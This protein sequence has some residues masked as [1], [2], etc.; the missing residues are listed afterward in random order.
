[1]A[2]EAQRHNLD[3]LAMHLDLYLLDFLKHDALGMEQEAAGLIGKPAYEDVILEYKSGTAAYAGQFA[4]ARDLTR[5][6][7]DSAQRVDE[8]ETAAG[9][10][11]EAAMREA[12]IGNFDRAKQQV[13][14]ATTLS[15]G[16]DV[17][18]ICAIVLAL[19]SDST[20]AKRLADNLSKRFPEDT[21]TQL[22]YLPMIHAAALLRGSD[23]AGAIEALVT[24]APYE[25]ANGIVF[26][27]A[28]LRGEAYLTAKQGP[29]AAAEFQKILD[30]AGI[31]NINPIGALAHLQLARAHA[32]SRDATKA[33]ADYQEFFTLWKN[34]DS[35]IPILNQAK[36]EYAKLQ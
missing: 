2:Q 31:V 11:A 33:R 29:A 16:R 3:S 7:T 27:P 34:A 26:Y 15:N 4:K 36:A 25:F 19:V 12:L 21:I 13:R 28:Y 22:N 6:A 9:Y 35:D 17:E 10:T 24:A 23:P 30:H 18:G 8:K 32:L 14:A 5:R 20:Q 1:M